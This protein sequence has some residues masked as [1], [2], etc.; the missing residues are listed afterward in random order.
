[1]P[2]DE[3]YVGGKRPDRVYVSKEFE[4]GT[5]ESPR[6]ARYISRVLESGER[7]GFAQIK[8]ELVVR[9][10]PSGRQQIKAVVYVDDREIETLI[11]QRF[12]SGSEKPHEET[13]FSLRGEEIGKL[14]GLVS[15]AKTARFSGPGKVR[16]DEADLAT[17]AITRDAARALAKA[18]LGLVIEIAEREI[19]PRDVVALAYRKAQLDIFRRLLDDSTFFASERERA[20]AARDEDLWQR[21]FERNTWVFGYGLFYVFTSGW[22]Q[23]RLE[24]VVAGYSVAGSGKRADALLKTRGLVSSLCFVEIKTHST[25][26]L[27]SSPYR[28]EAWAISREL[29]GGIAQV[30]RTILSAEAQIGKKLEG[31]DATGH[32]TGELAFL[33]RPRSVVVAGNLREFQDAKGISESK[34]TSFEM[35][36]RATQTPEIVT[37]DELYERAR[38]IVDTSSEP[39]SEQS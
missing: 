31:R 20:K 23:R 29:A 17:F 27:E 10:T 18:D 8:K 11:L 30:Q 13:R 14:M 38:F 25:P 35:F 36:R 3:D 19:T 5:S 12:S 28:P 33:V 6:R 24:Q 16:I 7:D 32:P 22:N 26:L 37:Y 9:V 21:F 4:A 1:V 39:S 34:F 2:G 15:L